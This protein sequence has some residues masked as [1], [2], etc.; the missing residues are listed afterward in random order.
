VSTHRT[1]H[2]STSQDCAFHGGTTSGLRR[3][4]LAV[5]CLL[6]TL[7]VVEGV[8]ASAA[9]AA[10]SV[11]PTI[12]HTVRQGDT[13]WSISQSYG[14]TVAT[15]QRANK[16]TARS[17]IVPGQKLSIPSASGTAYNPVTKP[18][19]DVASRLPLELRTNASVALVPLFVSASKE[20]GV[21]VDLLMGLA[22]TESSWQPAVRSRDGAIGLGQLLPSTVE[23]V[24]PNLL[25][26]KLDPAIPADNLRMTAAYVRWLQKRFKGDNSRALAAY[27]EGAGYVEKHG[28]SRAGRNYAATV[29]RNRAKFSAVIR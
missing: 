12:V 18:Q 27:F 25:R 13:L 17:V 8:G 5:A 4:T 29:L 19:G 3:A 15:V 16:M 22:L 23:W 14:V 26:A 6:G 2:H 7:T 11:T 20:S 28:P 9:V 24:G 21:P 10:P 1:S